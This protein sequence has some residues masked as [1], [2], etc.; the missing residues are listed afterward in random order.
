ME[1]WKDKNLNIVLRVLLLLLLL[2]IPNHN[3]PHSTHTTCWLEVQ[4]MSNKDVE[5]ISDNFNVFFKQTCLLPFYVLLVEFV[6][7]LY[8]CQH[9]IFVNILVVLDLFN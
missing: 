9:S 1:E 4:K 6:T 7:P 2:Q 3:F 5:N 8:L